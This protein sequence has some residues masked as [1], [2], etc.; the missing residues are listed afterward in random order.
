M[1]IETTASQGFRGEPDRIDVL[2]TKDV[3]LDVNRLIT[4]VLNLPVWQY[5]IF[6]D[7]LNQII[8]EGLPHPIRPIHNGDGA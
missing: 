1:S 7:E 5:L 4:Q 6:S 3:P 2:M 8:E